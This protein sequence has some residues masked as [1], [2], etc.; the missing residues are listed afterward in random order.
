MFYDVLPFILAPLGVGVTGVFWWLSERR[1]ARVRRDLLAEADHLSQ[2]LQ[3]SKRLSSNL[4]RECDE[5]RARL[6]KA[7]EHDAKGRIRK[8]QLAA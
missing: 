2:R 4:G 3:R 1:N 5:L 6:S 7:Y 8:I